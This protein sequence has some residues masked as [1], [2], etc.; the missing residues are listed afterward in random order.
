MILS[1]S[2][3]AVAGVAVGGGRL[4]LVGP[5]AALLEVGAWPAGEAVIAGATRQDPTRSAE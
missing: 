3:A 5:L 1:A 2:F 4:A